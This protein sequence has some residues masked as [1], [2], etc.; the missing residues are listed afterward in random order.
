MF[1]GINNSEVLRT[2][3]LKCDLKAAFNLAGNVENDGCEKKWQKK[4]RK[5]LKN[6]M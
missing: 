3:V 2:F 4:Q 5:C 6:P 1:G